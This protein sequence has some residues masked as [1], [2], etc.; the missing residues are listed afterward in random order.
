[1]KYVLI[2][3]LIFSSISVAFADRYEQARAEMKVPPRLD[4]V[5]IDIANSWQVKALDNLG[6]I[7]N[8]V[9]DNYVTAEITP[10][11]ITELKKQGYSITTLQENISGMYYDNFFTE[12]GRGRYLTYTE[13]IDTMCVIATNHSNICKL[14]TLGMSHTNRLLLAMKISDSVQIDQSEPAVYFDGNTHG[15]EK[16]GWAVCFEFVKYM[17][18]YYNWDPIVTQLVNNREIWVVPM[19]N[20]DGYVSSSRYNGR[21]VDVNRNYGWMWGNEASCGADAY[22]ENEATAFYNL[23]VKQPFVVYTTYHAGDSIIS[24][25]WSYTTYDSAPEKFLIHHLA[26][27]YSQN[28]NN[29]PY[30]QGSV[31]MYLINGSSKDYCYGIGGEISWSIEVHNT[32]TPPATS[33]DP[34]FNINRNAML[35]MISKAGQGIHGIVTD[36][37]TGQPLY[38]QIWVMPRNWLSYSSP[39][40]G[41]FHRFYLPG[42]Y[43]LIVRCPGYKVDTVPVIVPNTTDSSVTVNIALHPDSTILSN[44]GMRVVSTRYVA[45]STNRTYPV[46]ALGIHDGIGFSVDNTK[47][48]IM[49]MARPI[50]NLIGNDF[51]V[52]RSTTS[53]SATVKVSNNWKGP[54]TTI[55]TASA[56][57]TSF[58]LTTAGLD[59]VRY[60]RLDATST[61][62]FDAVEIGTPQSGIETNEPYMEQTTNFN[63]SIYPNL[64]N[65][66][67]KISYTSNSNHDIKGYIY[68]VLGTKVKTVVLPKG[69][70]NL[71]IDTR[72]DNGQY[73]KSGVYFIKIADN[74][75]LVKRFTVIR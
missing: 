5:R 43:S 26:Q 16:I 48:I 51:T 42:T 38:A 68:D 29:Y 27:R 63:W 12:G 64:V 9:H 28:G 4:L 59:T 58:D 54:W 65:F 67:I 45:I 73:L 56:A 24:Y 72:T 10:Q 53:G 33:I 74:Q 39:V 20:P 34:T 57:Q 23:F 69:K 25:P 30:G 31:V 55:G 61:F 50:Q 47:W 18:Q 46:R 37:V 8:Q 6:V 71:L 7:I 17:I 32:K 14:E 35:Y 11:M 1:M 21:S 49:A 41:D 2:L 44:Y 60:V 19:F 15:D 70:D 36:S 13:Y 40:N 3:V 75:S 52:Y 62:G 66:V 22:S